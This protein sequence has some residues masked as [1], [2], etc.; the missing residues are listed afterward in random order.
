MKKERVKKKASRTLKG[1]YQNEKE[2]ATPIPGSN[3]PLYLEDGESHAEQMSK[4]QDEP[5][6]NQKEPKTERVLPPS[7]ERSVTIPKVVTPTPI[8]PV[9]IMDSI[10]M[11]DWFKIGLKVLSP[12]EVGR[13]MTILD[14]KMFQNISPKE[15]FRQ[16]W[17]RRGKEVNSPHILE[18][19]ER[20][21]QVRACVRVC[22]C[23]CVLV[24]GYIRGEV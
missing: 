15:C 11:I 3:F 12:T 8:L 20:F 18:M 14:A 17:M 5:L 10:S 13:Q 9:Q 23:M 1:L 7:T 6:G 24:D 16:R 2:N 22:V 4:S 21:N 19:V